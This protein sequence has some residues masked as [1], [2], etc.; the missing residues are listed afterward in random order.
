MPST[1]PF[2]N[3]TT[4]KNILQHVLSP[5]IVS[6]G[7]GGFKT[8]TDLVNIDAVNANRLILSLGTGNGSDGIPYTGQTGTSVISGGNLYAQAYIQGVT[9]QSIVFAV[10]SDSVNPVA[11][12]EC[13][14]GYIIIRV[15]TNAARDVT[16]KW[17]VA[18]Y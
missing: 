17:F 9:S 8:A 5:K 10:S 11:S 18:R 16:V 1:D 6:D 4:V 3:T 14:D 12:V 15:A 7:G 2:A 13:S